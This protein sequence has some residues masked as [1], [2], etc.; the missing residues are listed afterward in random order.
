[1]SGGGVDGR[2]LRAWLSARS[3]ARGLPAPV[4]D[5]GGFRVDTDSDEEVRRWVFAQA[6]PG[7]VDLANTITRPRH[8]LTLCGEAEELRSMLPA[9]WRLRPP[10]YF[11]QAGGT[12][13]ERALPVGYVIETGRR[14][15]VTVVRVIS[16]TGETAASGY[17]AET[18]DA[19]IYDRIVTVPEHRRR[20]LGRSV[21]AAL[22]RARRDHGIPDLLVATEDGRALY[23]SLGWRTLSAYSTASIPDDGR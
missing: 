12:P 4:A 9:V 7:L 8:V 16:N 23:E 22:R 19:F 5:R 17:A 14:G 2:T 18:R 6:E 15:A 21:M 10:G 20:G 3:I 11:M 1:M 13:D